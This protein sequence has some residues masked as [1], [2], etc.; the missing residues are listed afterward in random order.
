MFSFSSITRLT[1][2][3]QLLELLRPPPPDPARQAKQLRTVER[4]IMLP[5]K[6]VLLTVL[7]HYLYSTNWMGAISTTR[8]VA[9]EGIQ[10]FFLPYVGFNIVA[11]ALLIVMH[12]IP[13][14]V[15]QWLMFISGLLDGLLLASLTLITNGFDSI[16][17]WFF[18]ALILRNALSI[19]LAAQQLTMNFAVSGCYL[20]AG[21]LD[22]TFNQYESFPFDAATGRSLG[23]G[24]QENPTEPFLMRLIILFFMTF[25]CYGLQV[26][27]EKQRVAVEESHE[28][29]LRQE[30]LNAAARL[31]AEVAHQIKNPLSIINN[32]AFNL[33]RMLNPATEPAKQ[34]IG[35]IR[36]EV[37]RADRIIT[38]LL[39]YS[40]LT[41]S[42]VEKLDL[43]AELENAI[44][45]V[46]PPAAQYAVT[47]ERDL[48]PNLPILMMQR[49]HLSEI[50][51]NILKN[52]R[53]AMDGHGKIRL[54]VHAQANRVLMEI[55][56][57][58][59]GIPPDRVEKVFE[60]Y[61]TTKHTGTGLGLAI[62]RRSLDIYG[63]TIR[64]ESVPD[65]GARFILEFPTKANQ[66]I[67]I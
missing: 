35:I 31:A 60:A 62:V 44:E 41:Q 59:P 11:A 53:E 51:V 5:V 48:P 9:F 57:T 18:P 26:L 3:Q 42:P 16:L 54:R 49:G 1:T 10:K 30:Q 56:D 22:V 52:S 67:R 20:L 19:P 4:E 50:L 43:S 14:A 17:Y 28:F 34:Q 23:L 27:F 21:I 39:G 63:G 58:G 6:L 36:E 64:V 2:L 8:E 47:I 15:M 66:E 46:F 32:A 45:R 55:E 33:Q 7:A 38:E 65:K 13:L 61:Y 12:R 37:E 40:K 24:I 25:I 29:T